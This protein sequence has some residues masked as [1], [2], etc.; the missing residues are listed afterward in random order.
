M[1]SPPQE[2]ASSPSAPSPQ[3]AQ[4][5]EGQARLPDVLDPGATTEV[6]APIVTPTVSTVF[7]PWEPPVTAEE[8]AMFASAGRAFTGPGQIALAGVTGRPGE[9]GR[10]AGKADRHVSVVVTVVP[11][12]GAET[13]LAGTGGSRLVT[14]A[15]PEPDGRSLAVFDL[16]AP[17]EAGP[18]SIRY[19]AGP[20]VPP[21]PNPPASSY[22][23]EVYDWIT[24]TWRTLPPSLPF[25]SEYAD[26]PLDAGEVSSGLVRFRTRIDVSGGRSRSA[27]LMLTSTSDAE[28]KTHADAFKAL[29][30]ALKAAND[31]TRPAGGR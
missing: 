18:L 8:L 12:T 15:Q 27:Q 9:T 3:P 2:S 26:A 10:P 16:T 14:A 25:P 28:T 13:I 19:L 11:L 1:L 5:Q 17:P 7:Q 30:E 4:V 20:P 23:A 24:G 31:A 21:V 6:D 22:L 29:T